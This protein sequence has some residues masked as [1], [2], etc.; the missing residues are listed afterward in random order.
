MNE[1]SV[2]R[3]TTGYG[4]GEHAPGSDRAAR[5]PW[6]PPTTLL[7]GHGLA[8]EAIRAAAPERVGRDRARLRGACRPRPPPPRPRGGGDSPR[9]D[10]PLVSRPGDGPRLS[11]AGAV[12]ARDWDRREVIDDDM[13]RD[14]RATRLLGRELLHRG[15]VRSPLLQPLDGAAA[16]VERPGWAGRSTERSAGGAR[17]GALADRATCR[18]TSP[19]TGPPTRSTS[20]ERPATRSGSRTSASPSR[21]GRSRR[22]TDG[23]PLRGVLRVVVARQLRVGTRL[24]SSLRDRPRRLRHAGAADPRQ[25]ALHG[26]GRPRWAPA[27]QRS[28]AVSPAPAIPWEDRPPGSDAICGGP[29]ATRSWLATSCRAQTAS[30][31]RRSCRS[32]TVSRASSGSTTPRAAW[33]STSARSADGISWDIAPEP[34][35]WLPDRRPGAPR[36]RS[37][38]P[39]PTTRASRGSR[40]ATTSPG[41]TATTARRSASATPTTSRP[42]TS[43]TTRSCRSTATACSSPAGSAADT[44]CSAARATTGTRRSATSSTR[45]ARTSSTGAAIVTSWGPCPGP[46]SRRRSAPGRPRSR[47]SEGWLLIYHGVLTSCNGFVYSMGAAL[48]DLDEPWQVVARGTRLPALAAGA[49]RA[50]RRRPERGLP[51]RRARRSRG[52]SDH[53]YYGAAD[54]VTC[55]AHGHLSELLDFVR[56]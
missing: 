1:P 32:R 44:R 39:T 14:R 5:A 28:R 20:A 46:G 9:P 33:T 52:G 48:L 24:R 8:V 47:P 31:T 29:P 15:T 23:V 27:G 38:S 43:S 19:R 4:T 55:V 2:R 16:R 11:P 7:L 37:A 3:P 26:I 10:E 54:T 51:V 40:T 22:S 45:R 12:Q 25:R 42:S 35:T 49:V 13:T 50:G 18:S 53:V 6:P 21:G 56:R 17:M 36:C 30:S 34:I 41:A